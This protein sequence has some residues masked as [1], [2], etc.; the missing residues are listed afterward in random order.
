MITIEYILVT[1]AVE[2]FALNTLIKLN[3]R[4]ESQTKI[5]IVQLWHALG[6][7]QN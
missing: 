3:V 2:G 6:T 5:L 7:S 1:V 4:V